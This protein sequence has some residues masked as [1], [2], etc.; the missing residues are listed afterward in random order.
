[1]DKMAETAL[2]NELN[3]VVDYQT[4]GRATIK[5]L[6]SIID[7]VDVAVIRPMLQTQRSIAAI[8]KDFIHNASLLAS[9]TKIDDFVLLEELKA[10]EYAIKLAEEKDER[11][12]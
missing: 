6:K 3:K 2:I 9:G 5:S 12:E 11:N 10:L 7:A 8:A 1:M 4:D